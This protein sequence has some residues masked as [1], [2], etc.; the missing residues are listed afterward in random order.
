[1]FSPH[2]F[3]QS[4]IMSLKANLIFIALF[5]VLMGAAQGKKRGFAT[6][7]S[8]LWSGNRCSRAWFNL[9]RWFSRTWLTFV[10]LTSYFASQRRC[11]RMGL[12]HL[13]A[14]Q[15]WQERIFPWRCVTR[16]LEER[17]SVRQVHQSSKHSRAC[18]HSEPHCE[19]RGFLRWLQY[20]RHW[21][22]GRDVRSSWCQQWFEAASGMGNDWLCGW[23]QNLQR[24]G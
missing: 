7:M 13:P 17:K 8:S 14:Y 15:K 22:L 1:M 3:Y 23:A 4:I 6:G 10:C 20:W 12:K 5:A 19:D 18:P 11:R 2:P 21:S 9:F 24:H 16:P